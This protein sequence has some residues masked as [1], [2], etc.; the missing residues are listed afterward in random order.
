MKRS[1]T[2]P[3]SGTREAER[4]SVF[5]AQVDGTATAELVLA[6][7]RSCNEGVPFCCN[8]SRM[9]DVPGAGAG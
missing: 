2:A 9:L 6:C 5:S 7:T 3:V 4:P 8:R 1:V